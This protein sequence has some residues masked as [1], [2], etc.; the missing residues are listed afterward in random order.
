MDGIMSLE[1]T[2][3]ELVALKETIELS[4]GFEGRAQAR[5]A[6][7]EILRQRQSRPAP[8]CLEESI[9]GALVRRIIPI[10]VQSAALRFKLSRELQRAS[11]G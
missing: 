5:N 11:L 6:I 9:L 2:R 7:R 10:D 4:P 8:L 1:L 3:T